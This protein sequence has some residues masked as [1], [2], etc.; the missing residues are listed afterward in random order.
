MAS[1][2]AR[3]S[4]ERDESRVAITGGEVLNYCSVLSDSGAGGRSPRT[5]CYSPRTLREPALDLIES[6]HAPERL[7]VDDDVR[8]AE[9]PACNRVVD[10]G[11][12]EFLDA[13]V[14]DARADVIGIEALLDRKSTRLNSS[15][16]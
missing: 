13:R 2:L 11:L 6:I 3:K 1:A 10:L 12:G 16:G 8:R 4:A 7:A 15:H 5:Y 9:D 14:G